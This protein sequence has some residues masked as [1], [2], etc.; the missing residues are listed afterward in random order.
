MDP[1]DEYLGTT[2]VLII[3]TRRRLLACARRLQE[4]GMI[5]PGIDHPEVYHQ[6]S[7]GTIL[8]RSADGGTPAQQHPVRTVAVDK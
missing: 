6:K 8:P 3:G 7:G 5:A 4:A 2:E 1:T